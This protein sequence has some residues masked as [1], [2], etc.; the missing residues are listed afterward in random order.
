MNFVVILNS[1]FAE[2]GGLFSMIAEE[3]LATLK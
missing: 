3:N 2:R 1:N